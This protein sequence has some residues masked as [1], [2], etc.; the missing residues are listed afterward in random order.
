MYKL[1]FTL[2]FLPIF[3]YS[4]QPTAMELE[5]GNQPP[6][7]FNPNDYIQKTIVHGFQWSGTINSLRKLTHF[8]R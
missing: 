6:Q 8:S 7:V 3:L 4:E 2:L 5:F 1:I